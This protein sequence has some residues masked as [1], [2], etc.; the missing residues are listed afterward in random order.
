MD[1][2]V[3]INGRE[4]CSRATDGKSAGAF[5]DPCWSPPPPPVG[6]IV[7]PYSNTAYARDLQNGTATVFICKTMVA[8]KDRSF[9]STSQGDEPAT[10][11][12]QK[13]VSSGVIKGKAYFKSWS[14]NVKF[15]GLEVPRHEDLMT[16][17]HGSTANTPPHKYVDKE[18]LVNECK[19]N[20]AKVESACK[21]DPNQKPALERLLGKDKYKKLEPLLKKTG[22]K[23]ADWMVHCDGLWVK[24]GAFDPSKINEQLSE[25][26]GEMKNILNAEIGDIM[27]QI[28]GDIIDKA[29]EAGEDIAIRKARNA[30]IRH[31]AALAGTAIAGVGVVATE[32]AA[33]IWTIG[34]SA[35]GVIEG[36]M[37]AYD[38]LD[39]F[40]AAKDEL[41]RLP[42]KIEQILKDAA[43][44]PEKAMTD[45]MSL[46]SRLNS[47]TRAKKCIFV[48]YNQAEDLDGHGCCPGQTGHHVLPGAMFY[49]NTNCP[50]YKNDSSQAHKNAPTI[51][52]EG[53][54]NNAEWGSHGQI[55]SKMNE[56]IKNYKK[57]SFFKLGDRN[58]IDYEDAR[59]MAIKSVMETFP[60]SLC[61]PKCLKEQLDQYY[62]NIC[63]P[64]ILNAN[65]GMGGKQSRPFPYKTGKN[66]K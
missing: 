27:T 61:K 65:S 53:A 19:K 57:P 51:C 11:G 2:N 26:L 54:T 4:A 13:G 63:K 28:K 25:L 50:N 42:S 20:V 29:L 60:E 3:F 14:P 1:T 15:E 33:T 36:G 58:K 62:S 21:K 43:D 31:A 35:W 34:D 7:V 52:V 12:F 66:S 8:Q 6:P 5:P 38:A 48:P 24:P 41:D 23:S 10:P 44:K 39:A 49:D 32:A 18:V 22:I 45:M 46:L 17:N 56:K 40:S 47:C 16:H 59:D 9:F 64:N 55:H 30:G 37:E